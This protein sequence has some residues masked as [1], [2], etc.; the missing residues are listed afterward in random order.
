MSRTFRP[1]VP[2][3][4]AWTDASRSR[5]TDRT[6]GREVEIAERASKD[7]SREMQTVETSLDYSKQR[8]RDLSQKTEGASSLNEARTN[9]CL[10][11]YRGNE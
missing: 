3:C 9:N 2:P 7:A 1:T 6:H 11:T 5:S 4:G 10:L 8:V